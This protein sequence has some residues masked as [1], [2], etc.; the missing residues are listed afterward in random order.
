MS[1]AHHK[2][3]IQ[4]YEMEVI[5]ENTKFIV[6]L[7]M[8]FTSRINQVWCASACGSDTQNY[9]TLQW[10]VSGEQDRIHT[11]AHTHWYMT[12]FLACEIGDTCTQEVHRMFTLDQCWAK[13]TPSH[14]PIGYLQ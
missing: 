9:V 8:T 1:T 5:S 6:C 12:L 7:E 10:Q 3:V 4:R 2:E 11:S 13:K 14:K